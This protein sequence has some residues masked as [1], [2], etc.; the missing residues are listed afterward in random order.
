MTKQNKP[1]EAT[2]HS[3]LDTK[4]QYDAP[5]LT[6]LGRAAELTKGTETGQ[7]CDSHGPAPHG[8]DPCSP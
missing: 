2:R 7:R 3:C 1:T 6:V 5:K 4:L 8:I